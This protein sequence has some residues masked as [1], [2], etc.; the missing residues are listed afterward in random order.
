VAAGTIH[1]KPDTLALIVLGNA[2]KGDVLDIARIAT[3]MGAKR[4]LP[5]CHPQA[6][7][8]VA[9]N[10]TR[11]PTACIAGRRWRRWARR[12]AMEAL[13]AVQGKL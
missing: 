12:G 9:V 5:L 8:R 1:M 11:R 3:I 6:L 13:T 10:W 7:P 4:T 2:K